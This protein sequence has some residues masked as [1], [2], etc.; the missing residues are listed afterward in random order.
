MKFSRFTIAVLILMAVG[1]APAVS[2]PDPETGS[3]PPPCTGIGQTWESP[4]DG[5]NAYLVYRSQ[6]KELDGDRL[7]LRAGPA[8]DK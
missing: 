8:K 7:R 2:T 4:I 5:V 1:C 6:V 3:Q